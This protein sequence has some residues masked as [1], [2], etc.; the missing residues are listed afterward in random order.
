MEES[1]IQFRM[2]GIPEEIIKLDANGFHYK[3][4]TVDDSGEAY[5]LFTEWLKRANN[6]CDLNRN[7]CIR[8]Y[9]ID[10]REAKEWWGGDDAP[11]AI[12]DMSEG[13]DEYKESDIRRV[14]DEAKRR[15]DR[16]AL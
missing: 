6:I 1:N 12:A 9:T 16:S 5:R 10:V 11:I 2:T 13:C 14:S 7:E 3:G 8:K 4:E 15:R